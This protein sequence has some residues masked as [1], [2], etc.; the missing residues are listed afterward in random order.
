MV[1]ADGKTMTITQTGTNAKGEAVNNT[2]V[3]NK[4]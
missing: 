4:Q 3:Y 2:N 1:S